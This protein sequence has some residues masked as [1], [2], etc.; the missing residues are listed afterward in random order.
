VVYTRT[1]RRSGPCPQDGFGSRIKFQ[2]PFLS[3]LS[4]ILV[5]FDTILVAFVPGTLQLPLDFVQVA[6]TTVVL[7]SWTN[8]PLSRCP[9]SLEGLYGSPIPVIVDNCYCTGVNG[10]KGCCRLAPVVAAV[11]ALPPDTFAVLERISA[12]VRTPTSSPFVVS[13]TWTHPIFLFCCSSWMHQSLLALHRH[14]N[15]HSHATSLTSTSPQ[16]TGTRD[17]DDGDE[18]VIPV[19]VFW[20]APTPARTARKASILSVPV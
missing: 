9:R 17:G 19:T 18:M 1:V 15:A 16:P 7:P 2:N 4:S 14:Q 12:S 13:P 5:S 10:R 20:T 6:S 8:P 3:G 11:D